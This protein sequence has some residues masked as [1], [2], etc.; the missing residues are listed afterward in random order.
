MHV[1]VLTSLDQDIGVIVSQETKAP[2]SESMVA[3]HSGIYAASTCNHEI[4][5]GG[6]KK[7]KY[8]S[9]GEKEV[10]DEVFGASMSTFAK[11][12]R[13]MKII[14]RYTWSDGWGH[15]ILSSKW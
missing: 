14:Q 10:G 7:R 8:M 12:N 13:K 5:L 11:C 15:K 2:T 6:H 4:N 9:G 3:F 1:I